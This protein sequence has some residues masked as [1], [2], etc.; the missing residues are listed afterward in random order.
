M[1]SLSLKS[2]FYVFETAV[3]LSLSDFEGSDTLEN[4]DLSM[5][6]FV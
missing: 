3:S 6:P 2:E 5:F 1:L 4:V